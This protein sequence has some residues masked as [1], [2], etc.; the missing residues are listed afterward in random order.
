MARRDSGLSA[1]NSTVVDRVRDPETVEF[2]TVH[3]GRPSL[4]IQKRL[5]A[6]DLLHHTHR[7]ALWPDA[8][9][10]AH[11]IDLGRFGAE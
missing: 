6:F 8:V 5:I 3:S 10:I 9:A 11:R 4:L 1:R 7:V 2:Y